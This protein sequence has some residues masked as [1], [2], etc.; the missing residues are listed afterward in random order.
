MLTVLC[1]LCTAKRDCEDLHREISIAADNNIFSKIELSDSKYSDTDFSAS[2]QD[3]PS[4]PGRKNHLEY[5]R[6]CRLRNVVNDCKKVCCDCLYTGDPFN[7]D[8]DHENPSD[9]VMTISKMINS[10]YSLVEILTEMKKCSIRCKLCHQ[11]RTIQ[12]GHSGNWDSTK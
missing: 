11:I 12:E 7:F 4:T 6:Q 9:K 5:L 1:K 2:S 3:H 10:G 8:C